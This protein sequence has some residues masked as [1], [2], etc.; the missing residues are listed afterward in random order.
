MLSFTRH[1]PHSFGKHRKR[2]PALLAPKRKSLARRNKTRTGRSGSNGLA[3]DFDC[4]AIR[5]PIMVPTL[6]AG[7]HTAPSPRR[8]P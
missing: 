2:K 4:P 1:T 7:M 6:A 3:G 5:L 8:G